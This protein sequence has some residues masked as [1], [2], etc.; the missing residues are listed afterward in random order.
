M[1]QFS[2]NILQTDIEGEFLRLF[3]WGDVDSWMLLIVHASRLSYLNETNGRLSLNK[4]ASLKGSSTYLSKRLIAGWYAWSH[5][6]W[7][8]QWTTSCSFI[9][10][11]ML[12]FS[13]I[14]ITFVKTKTTRIFLLCLLQDISLKSC[15]IFA[16]YKL[17]YLL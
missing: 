1:K 17:M 14:F 16:W 10:S 8:R 6:Q 15:A 11:E 2:I 3:L 12:N 13:L 9:S 7:E 4:V 5:F